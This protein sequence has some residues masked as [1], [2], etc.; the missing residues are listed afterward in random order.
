[1]RLVQGL[2]I[3][4]RLGLSLGQA[5]KQCVQDCYGA[6][7]PSNEFHNSKQHFDPPPYISACLCVH[8]FNSKWTAV[9]N[10]NEQHLQ[11]GVQMGDTV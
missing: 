5:C 11:L 2:W 6:E 9:C 4:E 7:Y 1:M 10:P 8:C 3:V